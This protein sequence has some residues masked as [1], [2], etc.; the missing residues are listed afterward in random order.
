MELPSYRK[1]SK[2][3]LDLYDREIFWSQISITA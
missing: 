3:A 2:A 1:A